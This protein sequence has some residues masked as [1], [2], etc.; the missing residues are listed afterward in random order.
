[1]CVEY[2]RCSPCGASLPVNLLST[3]IAD[4]VKEVEGWRAVGWV[5]VMCVNYQC[6]SLLFRI[7]RISWRHAVDPQPMQHQVNKLYGI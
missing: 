7:P 5:L 3:S 6:V 4:L 1:M 2:Q